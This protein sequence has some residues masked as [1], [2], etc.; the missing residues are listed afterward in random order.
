MRFLSLYSTVIKMA[1]SMKRPGLLPCAA[2]RLV[3]CAERHVPGAKRPTA[4]DFEQVKRVVREH[5]S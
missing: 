2:F 1:L 4:L 3:A 5:S